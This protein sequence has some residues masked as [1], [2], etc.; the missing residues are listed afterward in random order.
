MEQ[1]NEKRKYII[2]MYTFP[3]G[4]RYI[5]KTSATLRQRQRDDDW[6]GYDECPA[7]FNAIKKYKPEN[8]KQEILAEG[9]MTKDESS[10]I[11]RYYIAL[12]K[13]NCNRYRNPEYGYNL[14]DGGDDGSGPRPNMC[15][16]NHHNAKPVYCIET[17]KY[18]GS[19]LTAQQET[20]FSKAGIGN[21][22]RGYLFTTHHPDNPDL[23]SHWLFAEDV[24]EENINRVL[25]GPPP[26]SVEKMVYCIELDKYFRNACEA[27]REL[28]I[29]SDSIRLCC[30]G[31]FISTG[32]YTDD[33]PELHWLWSED[34]NDNNIEA[35]MNRKRI[36]P[37][38]QSVY[39]VE[40][41]AYFDTEKE[42]AIYAGVENI[43]RSLNNYGYAS[44]KHP[45]TGQPL[46]WLKSAE[47]NDSNIAKVLDIA[48]NL[49][50]DARRRFIESVGDKQRGEQN[51]NAKFTEA[52]VKLIIQ[53]LLNGE[54][55]TEIAKDYDNRSS[56]ISDIKNH[57]SWKYLTEGIVFV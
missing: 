27:E 21:C 9:M 26:S 50:E 56:A 55:A 25:A 8:I 45:E 16:D 1:T 34:V 13:T 24:T 51:G 11:E 14:T 37:N 23:I 22:C 33:K 19:A 42:G 6:S 31:K 7:V 53:R 47:V 39:C 35:A 43:R 44:G 3:N 12:Y 57:R 41:G 40:T 49:Q 18:Y 38:V 10:A 15:G 48:A 52:D 36:A 17:G 2:Y 5:G 29:L 4:K 32:K 28:G 20:G 54:K 46:H 30:S